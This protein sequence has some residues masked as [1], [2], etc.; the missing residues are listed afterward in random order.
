MSVS[1]VGV[2]QTT[3]MESTPVDSAS[4]LHGG[5]TVDAET[6]VEPAMCEEEELF[7]HRFFMGQVEHAIYT[8]MSFLLAFHF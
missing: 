2:G 8:Y 6:Y 5:Y 1:R 4:A 3:R 7:A